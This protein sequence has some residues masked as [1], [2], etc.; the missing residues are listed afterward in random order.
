MMKMGKTLIDLI[1]TRLGGSTAKKLTSNERGPNAPR[2]LKRGSTPQYNALKTSEESKHSTEA[3]RATPGGCAR[4][5]PSEKLRCYDS[6]SS[7]TKP[8]QE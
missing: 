3:S 8:L 5:H 6:S 7:L 1:R 4:T 2:W